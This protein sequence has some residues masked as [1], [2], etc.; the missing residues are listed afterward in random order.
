MPS[1]PV[2]APTPHRQDTQ[3]ETGRDRFAHRREKSLSL[4]ERGRFSSSL[5]SGW[6]CVPCLLRTSTFRQLLRTGA[7]LTARRTI[8]A[9]AAMRCLASTN[10]AAGFGILLLFI[11][12]AHTFRVQCPGHARLL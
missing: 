2:P 8:P 10:P 6:D 12:P 4:R 11:H 3:P 5:V 1:R 7:H 9:V